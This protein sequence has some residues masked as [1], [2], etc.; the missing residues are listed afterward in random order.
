MG[1]Q[2]TLQEILSPVFLVKIISIPI[3]YSLQDIKRTLNS[4]AICGNSK[5][6]SLNI[7][8]KTCETSKWQFPCCHWKKAI[9]QA[10]IGWHVRYLGRVLPSIDSAGKHPWPP[11]KTQGQH[12]SRQSLL[13]LTYNSFL[14]IFSFMGGLFD[15]KTWRFCI[16]GNFGYETKAWYGL[17]R[18]WCW[19][20]DH[21]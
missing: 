15:S 16:F 21:S 17:S 13:A 9:L 5:F 20:C 2:R 7:T 18:A 10:V 19:T 8:M 6:K 12:N 14:K 4:N 1:H 11:A 3:Q